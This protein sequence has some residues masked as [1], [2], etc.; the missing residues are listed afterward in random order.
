MKIA[1]GQMRI[2]AGD[3]RRNYETV[4]TMVNEV[5]H[6]ADLIVFPELCLSGIA[7]GDMY[8]NKELLDSIEKYNKKVA[9]LSASI[10]IV[11]GSVSDGYNCAIVAQKGVIT[12]TI[13]KSNLL[14][15]G[16]Y[17]ESRY[18]HK[19]SGPKTVTMSNGLV[20]NVG[21]NND[22]V[23]QNFWN[24]R[25]STSIFEHDVIDT[26]HPMTLEAR[27]VGLCNNG[28]TVF[29]MD[30]GS[31][32]SHEERSYRLND[33]YEEEV[34]V[35]DLDAFV[36]EVETSEDK[37]LMG[38][39][40]TIRMF[41]EENLS[42]KPKWLVGV[43]GGL[44]SSLSVALLTMALG[45][46][47]VIG[48]TM[49]GEYTR[50]ITKTNAYHLSKSLGFELMEIAIHDTVNATHNSLHEVGFENVSGL[51]H[52][53]IQARLRGHILMSVASLVNGVV[54]NNGNMIE[55]AMGYATMYGDSIGAL[56][57]LAD[58]S[59]LEVG[60]IAH[61]INEIYEMEI[62]PNNLIPTVHE[63]YIA[64]EFAPSAELSKDQFDPMKWGYHDYLIPDIL[65]RGP[66]SILEAY[67]DK[68]HTNW[69]PYLNYYGLLDPVAF[70]KDLE[71]VVRTLKLATFKRV[72]SPPVIKV[73]KRSFGFDYLEYQG[74]NIYSDAYIELKNELLEGLS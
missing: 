43:S 64:W 48:I 52:E 17:F 71:W 54:S 67:R 68:T 39:I 13:T 2:Y 55:T 26:M 6:K 41:D 11:F 59:K 58:L 10:D 69:S 56:S 70:I 34:Q 25:V 62:I 22:P 32:I 16:I 33:K 14:D 66:V 51:T 19:G 46:E 5:L 63:S 73:S 44:D 29:S 15:E 65:D 4:E 42:Y 31:Y 27:G 60:M 18:F 36:H 8:L 21:V 72:Q 23:D 12:A 1:I 24:L 61:R 57:L 3:I 45:K 50:D 47:R 30:G 38:L 35:V 74:P 20:F 28:K 53:N 40:Q 7:L 9:A 37:I 49:P